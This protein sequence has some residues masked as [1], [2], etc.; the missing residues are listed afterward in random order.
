MHCKAHAALSKWTVPP[1]ENDVRQCEFNVA[2]ALIDDPPPELEQISVLEDEML[3]ADMLTVVK[4]LFHLMLVVSPGDRASATQVLASKEF[5][6]LDKA[7]AGTIASS[8]LYMSNF[9]FYRSK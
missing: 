1:L 9:E 8:N 4:D 2:K 5:L 6:A 7:L 3:K